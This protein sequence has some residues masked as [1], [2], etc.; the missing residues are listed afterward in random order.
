MKLDKFIVQQAEVI[1]DLAKYP[2]R[3]A[4]VRGAAAAVHA[5]RG[6][7]AAKPNPRAGREGA[8]EGRSCI[9]IFLVMFWSFWGLS[10]P[11]LGPRLCQNV[12]MVYGEVLAKDQPIRRLGDPVRGQTSL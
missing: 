3:R 11:P 9:T 7:E 12:A 8:E 4:A 6:D 10:G 1:T 2:R 5:P